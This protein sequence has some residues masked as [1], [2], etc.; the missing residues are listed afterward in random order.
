MVASSREIITRNE[1]KPGMSRNFFKN[2]LA[3]AAP[4]IENKI[5]ATQ[6]K[7]GSVP[8]RMPDDINVLFLFFFTQQYFSCCRMLFII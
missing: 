5:K 3:V 7:W 1:K 2:A 8:S 4:I 6:K